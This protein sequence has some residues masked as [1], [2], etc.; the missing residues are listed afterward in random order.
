MNYRE[1]YKKHHKKINEGWHIHHIDADR[2]NNDISNLIALPAEFHLSLH[3]YIGLLPR[4]KINVLLKW[5]LKKSKNKLSKAYL[6]YNL[7]KEASKLKLSKSL[8]QKNKIYIKN[9]QEQYLKY[10]KTY[11][12]DYYTRLSYW[13]KQIETW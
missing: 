13:N 5:Y 2:K 7:K 6:E 9:K 12:P 10:L 8:I 4:T 11:A 3:N 1:I